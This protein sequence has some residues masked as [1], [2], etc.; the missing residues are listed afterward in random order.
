M[1]RQII[2]AFVIFFAG[3]MISIVTG[4]T[5]STV[6]EAQPGVAN[7]N[8]T[9]LNESAVAPVSGVS[10]NT[11]ALDTQTTQ[12]PS[13]SNTTSN[14]TLTTTTIAPATTSV[15]IDTLTTLPTASNVTAANAT[16]SSS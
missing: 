15:I 4:Q 1:S 10:T 7:L 9:S 2:A 5:N 12:A 6:T 3:I 14:A 8:T 11:T 13:A 16:T